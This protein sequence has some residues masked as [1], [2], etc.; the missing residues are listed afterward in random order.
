MPLARSLPSRAPAPRASG[1]AALALFSAHATERR[2]RAAGLYT[3]TRAGHGSLVP[4]DSVLAISL[5]PGRQTGKFRLFRVLLLPA[6]R[7]SPRPWPALRP[8]P[9]VE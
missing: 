7:V 2:L 1:A 9:Q 8:D 5:P 6:P 4:C 3:S